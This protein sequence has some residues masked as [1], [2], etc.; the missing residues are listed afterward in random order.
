[1]SGLVVPFPNKKHEDTPTFKIRAHSGS[2]R[3]GDP[4][5]KADDCGNTSGYAADRYPCRC[6][7]GGLVHCIDAL[8][9]L[10]GHYGSYGLTEHCDMCG[11]RAKPVSDILTHEETEALQRI[12][13]QKLRV[14]I[15]ASFRHLLI[16]HT[17]FFRQ[18]L[19]ALS[20]LPRETP[21][22]AMESVRF[23]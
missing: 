7:C 12:A 21:W 8:A 11:A 10:A 17:E 5:C 2:H 1:M 16:E 15:G 4:E 22:A 14:R 6:C 23:R 9:E 19:A 18:E 13:R 3:A 20:E